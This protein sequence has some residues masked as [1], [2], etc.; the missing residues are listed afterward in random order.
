MTLVA[1]PPERRTPSLA[2]IAA[3]ARNGTIGAHNTL[4]WKLPDDLRHFRALTLG[5]AVIMGRRTWDSLGRPLPGRQNIVVTAQRSLAPVGVQTAHSLRAAL[6]LVEMPGPVFCIGG[7]EL[8][9]LALPHADIMYLTE[10]EGDFDGDVRFPAFDRGIWS[11]TRREPQRTTAGLDFAF[12][13]YERVGGPS[14]TAPAT[15]ESPPI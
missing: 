5:H 10:I 11:E 2:L 3:V 8:Y 12:V 13:T 9:A 1:P 14:R 6:D 7:G 4:P 15:R